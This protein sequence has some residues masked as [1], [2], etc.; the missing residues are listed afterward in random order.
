MTINIRHVDTCL[1]CYLL[2]HH[3]RPG[4]LLVGVTCRAQSVEEVAN[5]IVDE[6]NLVCA[7]GLPDGFPDLSDDEIR[8]IG[9]AA[10]EGVDM[11]PDAEPD[12]CKECDSD[13]K[14]NRVRLD[15]GRTA[16]I[17][18]DC[19]HAH[20]IADLLEDFNDELCAAWFLVTWNM[21]SDDE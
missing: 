2:D 3:N 21:E 15:G 19:G 1:P 14:M 17:C 8:E 9:K 20:S 13:V 10:A 4:E 11:V 16:Y 7:G 12:R 5:E 6:I 18:D